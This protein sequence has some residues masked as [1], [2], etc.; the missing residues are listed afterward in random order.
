MDEVDEDEF[1]GIDGL[2][3]CAERKIVLACRNSYIYSLSL[4]PL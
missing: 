3:K 2:N 1:D 4:L